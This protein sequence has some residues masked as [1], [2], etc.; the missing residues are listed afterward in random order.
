MPSSSSA[1]PSSKDSLSTHPSPPDHFLC[2]ISLEVM[3][4]PVYDR[5][6]PGHVFERRAILEWMF[7]HGKGSN[8]LTRR[9]MA[10]SDLARNFQLQREITAWKEEHCPGL[11]L[12]DEDSSE[13]DDD[14]DTDSERDFENQD[15]GL[16]GSI[17]CFFNDQERMS[18]LHDIRQRVM[19][20]RDQRLGLVRN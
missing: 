5:R 4:Y 13:T 19:D 20:Q 15:C 2:P 1:S 7:V 10:V 12:D 16:D 9:T 6:T 14:D 3:R 17:D 18:R 8:P 11:L